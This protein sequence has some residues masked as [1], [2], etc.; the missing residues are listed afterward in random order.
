MKSGN[1]MLKYHYKRFD[2][3]ELF[4]GCWIFQ[5]LYNTIYPSLTCHEHFIM[6]TNLSA[7]VTQ[8]FVFFY[9]Q[10]LCVVRVEHFLNF[11]LVNSNLSVV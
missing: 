2:N 6:V 3:A 5:D 1:D 4:S 10:A 7:N 8:N 9:N 11:Y